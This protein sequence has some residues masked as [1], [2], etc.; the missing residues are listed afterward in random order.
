M[1]TAILPNLNLPTKEVDGLIVPILDKPYTKIV[2]AIDRL[3]PR[4]AIEMGSWHSCETCHCIAGWAIHLCGEQGYDLEESARCAGVAGRM[5]L[6]ASSGLKLPNFHPGPYK[7]D[8]RVDDDATADD[9]CRYVNEAALVKLR[10]LAAQ[11]AIL[12]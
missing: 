3:G 8:L 4:R 1:E 2:E 12:P 9:I 10:A 6:T 7:E 5:I 11:E